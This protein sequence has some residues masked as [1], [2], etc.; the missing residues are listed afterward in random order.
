VDDFSASGAVIC[1]DE[2]PV[3]LHVE[4]R[5]PIRMA[6]AKIAKPDNEYERRGT[7]NV[8]YAVEP[9]AE[10]HLTFPT[11]NRSAPEFAQALTRIV[12]HYPFA[13]TIHLLRNLLLG[14][15]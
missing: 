9:K 14:P 4:V 6:P 11:P 12:D 1:I 10:R 3:T 13:R 15:C 8:F 7:V 5:P 2:K